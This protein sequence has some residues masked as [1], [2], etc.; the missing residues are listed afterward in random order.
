MTC[1]L[2]TNR[3]KLRPEVEFQYRGHL[4]LETASC[5]ISA[6][7]WDIL[8]KFGMLIDY[9]DI[10]KPKTGNKLAKLWLPLDHQRPIFDVTSIFQDGRHPWSYN[11]NYENHQPVKGKAT[12]VWSEI[13]CP[14]RTQPAWPC[15][16]FS[17]DTQLA[18]MAQLSIASHVTCERESRQQ[19]LVPGP[20][21]TSRLAALNTPS[22]ELHH[23]SVTHDCFRHSLKA[24]CNYRPGLLL[25]KRPLWRYFVNWAFEML[26]NYSYYQA[27]SLSLE[28]VSYT[29][30]TL[31]TNRE[32]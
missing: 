26:V 32:V 9:L 1:R 7:D 25:A 11:H 6:V 2:I 24:L 23:S 17:N 20:F 3:S 19:R 22:P 30:L 31:P 15:L 29:H 4:Y 8:S 18:T 5:N 12:V 10:T 28:A 16:S 27:A 14:S 21:C 13:S